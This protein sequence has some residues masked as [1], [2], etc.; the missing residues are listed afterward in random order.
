MR[1]SSSRADVKFQITETVRAT[2]RRLVT[3]AAVLAYE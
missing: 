2:V 1:A 3:G